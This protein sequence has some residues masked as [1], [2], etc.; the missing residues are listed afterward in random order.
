MAVEWWQGFPVVPED[1]KNPFFAVAP[2]P[3]FSMGNEEPKNPF[4]DLLGQP[5]VLGALSIPF[6][7]SSAPVVDM[8]PN[9]FDEFL[10]QV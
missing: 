5:V 10:S 3:L 7:I 8:G 9:P 6:L 2:E 4:L 1:G